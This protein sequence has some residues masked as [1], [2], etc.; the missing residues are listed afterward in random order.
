MQ[1]KKTA[2]KSRRAARRGFTLI[3]LLVVIA[4]LSLLAAL[5]VG[6]VIKVMRVAPQKSTETLIMKLGT[7]IEA[8]SRAISDQARKEQIP[9]GTWTALQ[10]SVGNNPQKIIDAYTQLRLQQEF[11]TSFA[12]ALSGPAILGPKKE[13]RDALQGRSAPPPNNTAPWANSYESS[14]C[15]Y[16]ALSFDRM[17]QTFD[18]STLSPREV[19][20]D[21]ASG[22]KAL[23]DGW[24]EP[25]QFVA[26]TDAT[27]GII[28][29]YI[30]SAGANRIQEVTALEDL[31]P[32]P[33]DDLS[34]KFL[35]L[36]K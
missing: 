26:F 31:M 14:M 30:R 11:P 5:S 6:V 17:G 12:Q 36:G 33:A 10:G 35:R 16:L 9:M 28:N 13:Y 21:P 24:D 23:M 25:L 22:L 32:P 3:E 4:I 20:T 27:S 18:L 2:W 19:Y 1:L 7:V 15:L 8:Q 34:S 29:Y